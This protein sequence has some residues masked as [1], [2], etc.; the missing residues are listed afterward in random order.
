MSDDRV[1]V[2]KDGGKGGSG[3]VIALLLL[4]AIVIGGI[5]A[6]NY[7]NSNSAKNNAVTE[8]ANSV[9]NAAD[10]V[11]DAAVN[12]YV[13]STNEL[14]DDTSIPE[15]VLYRQWLDQVHPGAIP[16]YYGLFAWSAARLFAEEATK[17]GGRLS[18]SAFLD[19][20]EKVD[21]W[22]ANGLHTGMHIGA[23]RSSE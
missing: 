9:G 21:G 3:W 13:Y 18:R 23:K 14:F 15:M 2:V 22:T 7:V 11:G 19:A 16:N 8:A 17:L 1:V 5:L 20:L 4:A 6:M 10:Q 12:T